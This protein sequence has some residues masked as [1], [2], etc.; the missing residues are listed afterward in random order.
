MFGIR[1]SRRVVEILLFLLLAIT[2][3]IIAIGLAKHAED[4]IK[5]KQIK[6]QQVLN[7]VDSSSIK[8]DS[9]TSQALVQ[10]ERGAKA[11]E[12]LLELI[13]KYEIALEQLRTHDFEAYKYFVKS[14]Q[15]KEEYNELVNYEFHGENKYIKEKANS[16]K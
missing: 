9:I 11:N 12:H 2:L 7:Q 5:Q 13:G 14:A 4:G 16:Y 1:Y 10:V 8:C 6:S 15:F 3:L